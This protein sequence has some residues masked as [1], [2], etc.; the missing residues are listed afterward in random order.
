MRTFFIIPLLLLCS[1][2]TAQFPV[3][4]ENISGGGL[5]VRTDP[6]YGA[7]S[8]TLIAWH[9]MAVALDFELDEGAETFDTYYW[10]EIDLPDPD[11]PETGWTNAGFDFVNSQGEMLY[12][13]PKCTND[14]VEVT[15]PALNVEQAQA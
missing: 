2:L 3:V 8:I 5:Y 6:D 11:G 7:S 9:N 1:Q 4:L 15:W 12:Y 14:F 13:S 10:Y